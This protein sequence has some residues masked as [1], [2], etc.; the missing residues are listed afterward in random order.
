MATALI[1]AVPAVVVLLTATAVL[2][3]ML[4]TITKHPPPNSQ[5]SPTGTTP[6]LNFDSMRD[7]V[8]G[9]YNDLPAHPQ[10]AWAKLDTHCKEQTGYADF[11]NFWATISSVTLVSINPRD[12]TSVVARLKYVRRDGTSDTEDR[13]LKMVLEN[14]AILLDGSGRIGSV[15]GSPALP[16]PPSLSPNAIDQVMLTAD[17]LSKLLGVN[18]T[19]NPAGGGGGS[20]LAIKSSSYGMADHSGQVKPKSCVGVAFTGEHDVYAAA[21]PAAMKIQIFG[22]QYGGSGSNAAPYYVEETAAVFPSATQAQQILKSS[23]AQWHT[24]G[25]SEVGVTLGYENGRGFRL[26]D[27]EHDGDVIAV[28]MASW[29]GLNGLHACQQALG[30]RANVVVE[31]RTCEEPSIPNFNWQEP[32]NPAWASPTATPL[33][34]A[35]LN[36]VKI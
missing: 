16:Q 31:A 29:G 33:V 27:V 28:S 26:G 9:Y 15:S 7:F 5:P 10:E 30:V 24:C 2:L 8:T 17:E 19:S 18:V 22:E 12:V 14:G 36:K 4:P 11:Q 21:D 1:L 20:A 35:M 23:G 3:V 34:N 13:W 32:V 6:S 25:S